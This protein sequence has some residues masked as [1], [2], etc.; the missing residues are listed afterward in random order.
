MRTRFRLNLLTRVLPENRGSD[1]LA[2]NL[3]AA[4]AY[5]QM[6]DTSTYRLVEVPNICAKGII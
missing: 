6:I 2:S 4:V 5:L 3:V 1:L